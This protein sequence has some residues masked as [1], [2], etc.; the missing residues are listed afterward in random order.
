MIQ[1]Y[2]PYKILAFPEHIKKLKANEIPKPINAN[3]RLTGFCNGSCSFCHCNKV[4]N[5][6]GKNL[7]F[8]I[9]ILL[10]FIEEFN[11]IGGKSLVFTGGEPLLHPNFDLI[12]NST[13][14][15]GLKY[16]IITNGLLLNKYFD[17][18]KSAVWARISLNPIL[19]KD[20]T[21]LVKYIKRLS[22]EGVFVTTS[23]IVNMSN[24]NR[25]S[26]VM[27]V[28]SKHGISDIRISPDH[29]L[30]AKSKTLLKKQLLQLEDNKDINIILQEE[31]FRKR[32][33]IENRKCLYSEV[34]L[35]V[36]SSGL[37]FPCPSPIVGMTKKYAYGDLNKDSFTDIW[38]LRN[39][40]FRINKDCMKFCVHTMKVQFLD[41]C[42]GEKNHA[43]FI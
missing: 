29:F 37:I 20:K 9:D 2:S 43:E 40:K 32:D 33:L 25:L 21:D 30:D 7:A 17:I 14:T 11:E 28:L 6:M 4:E 1:E 5:D 26:K 27:S 12:V 35:R 39:P 13:V 24:F 38:N 22:D 41:Y 3:I 36:D 31:K 10:K 34:Q 16:G 23:Y 15:R 42:V 18:L 8:N 19:K